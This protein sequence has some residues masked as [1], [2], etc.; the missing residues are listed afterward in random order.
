MSTHLATGGNG[1]VHDL[2]ITP[3]E[4]RKAFVGATVG[5]LIEWYD[6]G[7]YGFLA[8]Y[9]G[10]NFFKDQ[11]TTGL[12]YA[13]LTFALAFFIRP[14]GALFFGPFA[15]K[16][17]RR[18]TLVVVI[19]LMSGATLAVGLLPTANQPGM[20][21]IAPA[22]LVFFRL[23]QGFSAGGE[24]S[25]VT[26]FIAEFSAKGRRGYAIA[27]LSAVGA[28]GVALGGIVVN[29]LTLTLGRATMMEW[30]WRIPFLIAGVL[31][32]ASLYIRL[33]LEDS[34][35]FR[36]MQ[37]E[38]SLSSSPLRDVFKYPRQLVLLVSVV[39]LFCS[40]FYLVMSYVTV[41]LREIA[42]KGQ[43]FDPQMLF[44][45]LLASM[46]VAVLLMPLGGI[47]TD[48]YIWRRNYML[49]FTVLLPAAAAWFFVSAEN[50]VANGGLPS[51]LPSL[52]VLSAVYGL[53][54]GVPFGLMSEMLPPHV[55]STGIGIVYN[56]AMAVFGGSMPY[57]ATKLVADTGSKSSP[58][59]IVV[60]TA[61][62]TLVGLLFLRREDQLGLD[63]TE[64]I[65][66]ATTTTASGS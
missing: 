63:D 32:A 53:F 35:I 43:K 40:S 15:D 52:L 45:Y 38:D 56:I 33:K 55:R 31:G 14:L 2:H 37:S 44:Y 23:M 4:R 65:S 27:Y 8:A 21:F 59:W 62:I 19:V 61:V 29:I 48:K 30:G 20:G 16:H 10:A 1:A 12:L 60:A 51:I 66:G 41:Y 7:I 3:Q 5:H 46:L 49:I 22:L 39:A 42:L 25:S 50:I 47:I 6:F 24:I 54:A 11:G 28:G 18:K 17:G 9:I 34:P 26:A 58:L 57:V 13:F 64:H 36:A